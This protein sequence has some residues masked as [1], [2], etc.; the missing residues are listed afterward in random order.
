MSEPYQIDGEDNISTLWEGSPIFRRLIYGL[1]GLG[2]IVCYGFLVSYVLQ[3]RQKQID[4]I[5]QEIIDVTG[6]TE[7]TI[8]D[9]LPKKH[10]NVV[11]DDN[12]K[13][14]ALLNHKMLEN[15]PI[16]ADAWQYRFNPNK[17]APDTGFDVYY[18]DSKAPYKLVFRENKPYIALNSHQNALYGIPVK[19]MSTYWVGKISV[20]KD[21]IYHIKHNGEAETLRVL[22]NG[23]VI[24]DKQSQYGNDIAIFLEKG[25]YVFEVEAKNKYYADLS[26]AFL[27][28]I[29]MHKENE[30]RGYLSKLGVSNSN[31]YFVSVDESSDMN[32]IVNVQSVVE[33]PYVLILSSQNIVNWQIY[34]HPPKAIIY[35][36][37]MSNVASVG[38]PLLIKSDVYIDSELL[39][40]EVSCSCHHGM[41]SCGGVHDVHESI[42]HV[43]S[44][45][46]M[47][48]VGGTG[49]RYA[50][51][52]LL[53][54]TLVNQELI[55]QRHQVYEQKRM[56]CQVPTS[57]TINQH[58]SQ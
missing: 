35:N 4:K 15:Y 31:L 32:K 40:T 56:A 42:Q 33:E 41:F 28:P 47:R 57:P 53:P 38:A 45:T 18:F 27:H 30:L 6:S 52:L 9:I 16:A 39:S 26:V 2:L 25:D 13:A 49:E 34:G 24:E 12:P 44:L 7:N 50:S 37:D 10:S 22:L 36:N 54:Q 58:N 46:G 48:L 51:N 3:L 11:L 43:E 19:D 8:P 14:K 55:N 20:S 21:G 23:R 17:I 1:I 5:N 29:I